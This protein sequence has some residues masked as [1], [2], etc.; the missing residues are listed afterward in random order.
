MHVHKSKYG[1]GDIVFLKV[2]D[3]RHPGMVVCV[4]FSP[5]GFPLYDVAWRGNSM[6]PHWECELTQEFVPDFGVLP[7]DGSTKVDDN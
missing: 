5:H 2:N 4:R 1:C 6:T 7:D 3:D